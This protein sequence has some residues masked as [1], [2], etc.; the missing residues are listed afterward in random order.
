MTQAAFFDAD[1]DA[2]IGFISIPA[3][4]SAS[5]S[6]SASYCEPGLTEDELENYGTIL[7]KFDGHFAKKRN[8]YERVLFNQRIQ[9]EGATTRIDDFI[10]A[11]YGYG[12]LE[13]KQFGTG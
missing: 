1:A 9:A 7:A 2:G 5:M 13:T 4:A 3:S 6:A 10:T 11:L 8:V 12:A